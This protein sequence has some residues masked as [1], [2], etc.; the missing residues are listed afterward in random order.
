M[1][2]KRLISMAERIC[3]PRQRGKVKHKIKDIV[4]MVLFASIA[5]ANEWTEI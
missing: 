1:E 5:N 3:D 2:L 4:A